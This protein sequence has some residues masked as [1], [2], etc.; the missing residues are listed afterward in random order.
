VLEKIV[1]NT[2]KIRGSNNNVSFIIIKF[3]FSFPHFPN[4]L[5]TEICKFSRTKLNFY[6][7]N[8]SNSV[9]KCT[10]TVDAKRL[11]HFGLKFQGFQ[12]RIFSSFLRLIY[13]CFSHKKSIN[14]VC[15]SKKDES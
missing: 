6:K 13:F 5:L 12:I 7:T 4:R 14:L 11:V 2:Q 10:S 8:V 9:V 3:L 1:N 15:D